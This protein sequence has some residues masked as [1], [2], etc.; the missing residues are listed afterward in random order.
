MRK[1]PLFLA[2]SL[3]LVNPAGAVESVTC[4]SPDGSVTAVAE[5]D[6][7][8]MRDGG[9]LRRVRITTPNLVL[10]TDAEDTIAFAEIAADRIELGLESPGAGP[11]TAVIDIVRMAEFDGDGGPDREVVVAG[12]ARI[13]SVGSTILT[14]QGW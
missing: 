14:C 10:A 8:A 13:A 5:V 4:A 6:F 1:T 9:T 12:V 7:N 2:I 3:V 11:M